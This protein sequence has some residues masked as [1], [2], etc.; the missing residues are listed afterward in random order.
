MWLSAI[1]ALFVPLWVTPTPGVSRM[2]GCQWYQNVTCFMYFPFPVC[3]VIE[4]NL[5]ASRSFPFVSKTV[6]T[7]FITV[8][9]K[10]MVNHPLDE[11]ALPDLT[12]PLQPVGYVGIKVCS[13]LIGEKTNKW[14][15][16]WRWTKCPPSIPPK[17]HVIHLPPPPPLARR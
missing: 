1:Y 2:R 7:D 12:T 9:T 3:Q 17:S 14:M 10:I 16:G 6:G 15:N 4:C 8:A 13:F 5:R 11:H